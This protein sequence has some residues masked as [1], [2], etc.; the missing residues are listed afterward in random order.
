M[1]QRGGKRKGAGRKS[2]PDPKKPLTIYVTESILN[3]IDDP[4]AVAIRALE[5]K[6][7]KG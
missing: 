2:L 1:K 4:R 7:K 5:N 6:A 3:A